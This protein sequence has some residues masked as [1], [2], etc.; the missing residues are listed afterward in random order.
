MK[1]KFSLLISVILLSLV[2]CQ[3]EPPKR[4]EFKAV[5]DAEYAVE[6]RIPVQIEGIG[7]FVAF[8]SAEI[9]A[10]VEG[11]LMELHFEEGQYVQEGSPL[12]TIDTKPYEAKLEMAIAERVQQYSKLQYAAEKVARYQTLLPE[13]YVATLDYIKYQTDM[14][15]LEG[16]VM[17]KDAE[18]RLAEINLDYCSINAPFSGITGKRLIDKGN[19]ITNDGKTMLVIKQI[20]PI[21]IDFSVPERD[22]MKIANFCKDGTLEVEVAFPDHPDITFS[23]TL[24]LIDNEIDKRTG[25]I[26]LR[27][28]MRN[29]ENIFWPG[30]FVRSTLIVSHIENAIMVPSSAVEMGQKGLFC[31]VIKDN[32][33]EYR[34]VKTGEIVNNMV[35]VIKGIQKDDLVVTQGQIGVRPGIETT[36][37]NKEILESKDRSK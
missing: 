36:I 18:I 27:A 32:K 29:C 22:F 28:Q 9:K 30:Q 11:R 21:F 1:T 37:R 31:Y 33:A 24:M 3:K 25:M 17:Q 10:Q 26:A 35:Q 12:F 13:N 14:T 6:Q 19:L 34:S 2:S 8:N 23:A 20:D 15:N 7:H 5:V 4:R 16:S